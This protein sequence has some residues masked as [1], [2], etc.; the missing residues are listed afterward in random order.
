MEAM[1]ALA[2]VMSHAFGMKCFVGVGEYAV[3]LG[4]R[5]KFV[6]TFDSTSSPN[7]R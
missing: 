6:S 5:P 3:I 2:I 1:H 4:C 7:A